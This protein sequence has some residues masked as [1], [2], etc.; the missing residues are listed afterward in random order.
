MSPHQQSS[1]ARLAL[2][3]VY[4][5]RGRGE[6]LETL[7]LRRAPGGR[8]PGSWE[9]VHGH[10]EA[11][12]APTD[13]AWR[14]V[15]EETGLTPARLYNLS[16]AEWFYLHRADLVVVV[17]AFAAF[18]VDGAV[19]LSAEHDAWQWLPIAEARARCAW[20]RIRRA[21]DDV[22][23]LLGKGEAGALE[24]VLRVR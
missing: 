16:R 17:P 7:L 8:S 24:D 14:E 1:L 9:A 12:E 15:K 5:L 4:V 23:V 13:A 2:V 22:G 20:P 6:T 11:E 19:A 21:L 10:I 18:V 3:D